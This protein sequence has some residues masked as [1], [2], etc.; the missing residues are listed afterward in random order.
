MT[1][2]EAATTDPRVHRGEFPV[3]AAGFRVR[4]DDSLLRKGVFDSL[5]VVEVLN[6]IEETWGFSCRRTT[7][8]RR[9]AVRSPTWR[10]TLLFGVQRLCDLGPVAASPGLLWTVALLPKQPRGSVWQGVRAARGVGLRFTCQNSIFAPPQANAA[11]RD[12][13]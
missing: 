13:W 3:H 1:E 9:I 10:A 7:L 2:A 11:P 8:R 12:W 4:D 6:F 5:G